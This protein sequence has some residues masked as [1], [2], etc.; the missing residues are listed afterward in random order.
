MPQVASITHD[1]VMLDDG[2]S[3][4]AVRSGGYLEVD[5][6]DASSIDIHIDDG[7]RD[8]PSEY[9]LHIEA[10]KPRLDG[11]MFDDEYPNETRRSWSLPAVNARM[12]FDVTNM[13]GVDGAMYR[14]HIEANEN[15]PSRA[16]NATWA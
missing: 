14:I 9:L 13:S 1:T 3:L 2:E 6:P 7:S 5:T 12:R 16:R 4:S 8:Q 10:F 15:T 11:W